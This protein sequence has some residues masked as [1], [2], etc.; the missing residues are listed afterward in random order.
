MLGR[1]KEIHVL[2]GETSSQ[3]FATNVAINFVV[4]ANGT[5]V[6][7]VVHV[8]VLSQSSSLFLQKVLF[9]FLYSII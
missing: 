7:G 3:D 5:L 4:E 8:L 9:Y 6:R 1:Y 2:E